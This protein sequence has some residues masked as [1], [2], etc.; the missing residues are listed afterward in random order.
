M[1]QVVKPIP[2]SMPVIAPGMLNR[3]Q[4]IPRKIAGKKLLAASP[5]AKATT[6]AT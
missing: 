6:A 2:H 3:F 4:K 5:N 1:Y